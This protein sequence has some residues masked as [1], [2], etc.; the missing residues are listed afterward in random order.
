MEDPIRNKDD[1][2][3]DDGGG[4]FCLGTLGGFRVS[5]GSNVL[6]TA[7]EQEYKEKKAGSGIDQGKN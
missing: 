4:H 6:E 3:A 5:G 1:N 7:E 2:K